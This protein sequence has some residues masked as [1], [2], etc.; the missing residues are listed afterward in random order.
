MHF[1]VAISYILFAFFLYILHEQPSFKLLAVLDPEHSLAGF[2]TQPF[3]SSSLFP[4]NVGREDIFFGVPNLPT[5]H[6]TIFITSYHYSSS[7]I[8][9]GFSFISL[10]S[11]SSILYVILHEHFC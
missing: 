6:H 3:L 11:F 9:F 1:L 2:P 10:S 5:Y 4:I 7:T 8:A